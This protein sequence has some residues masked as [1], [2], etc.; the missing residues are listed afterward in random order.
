MNS[1][2]ETFDNAISLIFSFNSFFFSSDYRI[3][4]SNIT[5][6]CAYFKVSNHHF[7]CKPMIFFIS[8]LSE[9]VVFEYGSL[10]KVDAYILHQHLKDDELPFITH[11]PALL[12]AS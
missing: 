4:P 9:F 5:L 11:F 10:S 6:D 8:S 3:T 12:E 2:N 1:N 7:S